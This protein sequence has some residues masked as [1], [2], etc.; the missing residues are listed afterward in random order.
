[1]YKVNDALSFEQANR[2]NPESSGRGYHLYGGRHISYLHYRAGQVH[3]KE[4]VP[5]DWYRVV[6]GNIHAGDV[7]L[8]DSSIQSVECDSD[9][10]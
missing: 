6:C 4:A 9:V 2:S 5:F 3:R 7:N 1:M 8:L 10:S